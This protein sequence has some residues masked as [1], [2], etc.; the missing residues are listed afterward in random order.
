MLEVITRSE[1]EAMS[2]IAAELDS[3]PRTMRETTDPENSLSSRPRTTR[4]STA[5]MVVGDLPQ[6][7]S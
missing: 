5:R 1:F 3:L 4:A 2:A 7:S 6:C